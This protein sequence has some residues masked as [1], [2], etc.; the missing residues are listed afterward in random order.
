MVSGGY[1]KFGLDADGDE[2]G[3]GEDEYLRRASV[4]DGGHLVYHDGDSGIDE[5]RF[6]YYLLSAMLKPSRKILPHGGL[7]LA[8]ASAIVMSI[9]S[10]V[11]V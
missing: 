1:S 11:K 2:G 5:S 8:A 7:F 4:Y 3:N 9:F 6:R 10:V